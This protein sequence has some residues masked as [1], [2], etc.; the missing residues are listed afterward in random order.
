M[1][2]DL[3]RRLERLEGQASEELSALWSPYQWSPDEQLEDVQGYLDFHRRFKTTA[4]CTDR[5]INLLGLAAAYKELEGEAGEW[6]APSGAVVSLEDNGDGTFG[7]HLSSNLTV[8]DL[9]EGMREHVE[10]MDSACL[11]ERDRWLYEHHRRGE[12]VT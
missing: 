6:R 4:V 5:E 9:P 10:R 7:V 12:G 1:G 3:S 8:E 11:A 2:R